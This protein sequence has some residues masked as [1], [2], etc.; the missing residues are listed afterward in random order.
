MRTETGYTD[1]DLTQMSDVATYI[2]WANYHGIDLNFP[3]SEND[4]KWCQAA[5]EQF[6]YEIGSA[7]EEFGYLASNEMLKM[8]HQLIDV[9]SLG[10]DPSEQ[11]L[12]DEYLYAEE[13]G[14]TSPDMPY[15]MLLL[16]HQ[17]TLQPLL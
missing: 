1:Y 7:S 12:L 2:M 17:E 4:L 5:Y 14:F 9:V 16:G 3:L 6:L 10:A 13:S 8:I 15:F 11:D